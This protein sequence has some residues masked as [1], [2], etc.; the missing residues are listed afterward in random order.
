[1][2][3]DMMKKKNLIR[4]CQ[5]MKKKKLVIVK[6]FFDEKVYLEIL[7]KKKSRGRWNLSMAKAK[8]NI[9]QNLIIVVAHKIEDIFSFPKKKVYPVCL[10]TTRVFNYVNQ[11]FSLWRFLSA[12]CFHHRQ[13]GLSLITS[14]YFF[15]SYTFCFFFILSSFGDARERHRK[16]RKNYASGDFLWSII[17]NT[18]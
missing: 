5:K 11:V 6:V 3:G 16:K 14:Q 9:E 2:S 10:H 18:S 17:F 15:L 7:I 8:A 4:S 1:M 13:C 12:K